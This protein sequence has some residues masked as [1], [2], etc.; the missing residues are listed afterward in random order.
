MIGSAC[1]TYTK[2]NKAANS[3]A[4]RRPYTLYQHP[5]TPRTSNK[6]ESRVNLTKNQFRG[7]LSQQPTNDADRK[8]PAEINPT[9][10]LLRFNVWPETM[11]LFT[12]IPS[13]SG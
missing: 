7:S 5:E 12:G 6:P 1:Q 9:I 10:E 2:H 13:L 3:V 11:L 4:P 8:G